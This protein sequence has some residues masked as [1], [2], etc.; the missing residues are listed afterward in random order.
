MTSSR[1]KIAAAALGVA[2]VT[3]AAGCG[4][5]KPNP[6]L[7]Q[8]AP[9]TSTSAPAPTT[10]ASTTAATPSTPPSADPTAKADA[11][12]L[13]AYNHMVKSLV[14]EMNSNEIASDMLDYAQGDAY[15]LFATTLKG[16]Q[17]G[18]VM[19]VGQPQSS[20]KVTATD[21]SANP[22]SVT[23]SDCFGGPN[24]NLVYSA[25][26]GAYKKGQSAAKAVPPHVVNATL[27]QIDGSW[28]VLTYTPEDGPAC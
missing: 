11:D 3:M 23:V 22:P 16:D 25:T 10:S 6:G 12:A 15:K 7:N 21:L 8:A 14:Q 28:V 4:S 20:P 9:T 18:H 19:F 27:R 17:D 1:H 24:W 5:S 13:A 2:A 26:I